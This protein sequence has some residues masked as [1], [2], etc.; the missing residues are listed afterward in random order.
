MPDSRALGLIRD[1]I[2]KEP[3]RWKRVTNSPRFKRSQHLGGESLKKAPLGYTPDHPLIDDLRRKGF[4]AHAAYTE[5]Q[6]CA[7]DFLD[8][9]LENCRVEAPLM[10]FLAGALG[11]P[12]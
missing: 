3:A 1:A 6:V 9:F 12:W 10:S 8:R 11:V 7:A 2:V 4:F 5:K